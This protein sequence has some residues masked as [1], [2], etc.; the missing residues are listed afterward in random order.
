MMATVDDL[1]KRAVA[2]SRAYQEYASRLLL[3]AHTLFAAGKLDVD[4]YAQA[5]KNGQAMLAQAIAIAARAAVALD[6]KI[7]VDLGAL[8][9]STASLVETAGE[10]DRLQE[11]LAVSAA[12][13]A[14]ITAVAGA[15]LDPSK[16]TI[17]AAVTAVLGAG[18]A[19]AGAPKKSDTDDD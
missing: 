3:R 7:D 17:P 14:A 13:L 10:I 15:I 16:A 12:L 2:L 4:G 11:V 6:G 5:T 1:V 8:E 19:I 9:K 18:T